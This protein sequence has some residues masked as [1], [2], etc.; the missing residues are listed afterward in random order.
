MVYLKFVGIQLFPNICL[1]VHKEFCFHESAEIVHFYLP[2]SI[3]LLVITALKSYK[4]LAYVSWLSFLVGVASVLYV[5]YDSI[6]SI[7]DQTD[8]DLQESGD[9]QKL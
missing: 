2:V 5:I 8:F 6:R 9:Q 1:L 7:G 3:A 4:G